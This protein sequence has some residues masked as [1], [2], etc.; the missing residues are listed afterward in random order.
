VD[1]RRYY[2]KFTGDLGEEMVYNELCAR[3]YA[4]EYDVPADL[5]V[6]GVPVE[7]KTAHVSNY[8]S[9][10]GDGYQFC[11]WRE[12]HCKV[13]APVIVLVCLTDSGATFFVVPSDSI[14]NRR[15]IVIS[16]PE[17]E[18]YRGKWMCFLEKWDVIAMMVNAQ[19]SYRPPLSLATS[20]P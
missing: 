10:R 7:V 17:P 13:Q 8:R 6:N 9:E 16:H 20:Q 14:G 2:N 18:K 3:G 5:L 15:K 1:E 19:S 12:G 4:V 11:I